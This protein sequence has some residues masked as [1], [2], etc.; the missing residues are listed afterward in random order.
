MTDHEIILAIQELMNQVEW[1]ADTLEEIASLLDDNG[2][3]VGEEDTD[4]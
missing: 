4:Q 2:Y 3:N 1:D